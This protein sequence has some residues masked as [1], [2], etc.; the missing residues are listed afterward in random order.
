MPGVSNRGPTKGADGLGKVHFKFKPKPPPKGHRALAV[1]VYSILFSLMFLSFSWSRPHLKDVYVVPVLRKLLAGVDHLKMLQSNNEPELGQHVDLQDYLHI[2]SNNMT[3]VLYTQGFMHASDRLLQMEILRRTAL[4]TLSEYLGNVSV[5]S[6]KLY[7]TLNLADLA[8]Q[9]YEGMDASERA[10]LVSYSAGVNGYLLESSRGEFGGSLPLDFDLLF[11]IT[12]KSYNILPWE[13]FHTLA[14]LRLLAYEWGHG[15]EDQIKSALFAKVL[16]MPDDTLW[17]DAAPASKVGNLAEQA[18][19][20]TDKHGLT[21]IPSLNGVAVAVG[22]AKS[23]SGGAL[24]ANSMN[25]LVCRR[26][27]D[28]LHC[29]T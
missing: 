28:L 17:Y 22:G 19:S 10:H 12:S 21:L 7:R 27:V 18:A 20:F 14:V 6:D 1:V 13:P 25:T 4:G 11:G 26:K 5:E 23:A 16:H 2:K 29:F 15:W 24:L 3:S 9:D 8:K